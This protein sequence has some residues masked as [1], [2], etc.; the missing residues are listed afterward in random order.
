LALRELTLRAHA[1]QQNIRLDR[2]RR[3]PVQL[4]KMAAQQTG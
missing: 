3:I 4:G 2:I 1:E